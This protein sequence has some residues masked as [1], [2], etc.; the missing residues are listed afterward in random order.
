[1]AGDFNALLCERCCNDWHLFIR[2]HPLLLALQD[3]ELRL[4]IL[5]SR[6]NADGIDRTAEAQTIVAERRGNEHGLFTVAMNWIE[7]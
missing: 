1:M 3:A 4:T 6:T 7:D 5:L 2:D